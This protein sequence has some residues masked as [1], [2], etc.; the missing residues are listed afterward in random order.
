MMK[1]S[2]SLCHIY[3]DVMCAQLLTKQCGHDQMGIG[4]IGTNDE[5][6]SNCGSQCNH[7]ADKKSP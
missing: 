7:K 5:L 6:G 2:H 4:F 1:P 3:I